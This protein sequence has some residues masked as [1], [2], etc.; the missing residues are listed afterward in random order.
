MAV[1]LKP[2]GSFDHF[3]RALAAHGH[4]R[5][6]VFEGSLFRSV[7]PEH[8]VVFGHLSLEG[9]RFGGRWNPPE[10]F[11]ALY[12]SCEEGTARAE[13]ER[14]AARY[15][16][17]PSLRRA[18]Q[19]ISFETR[20]RLHLLDLRNGELLEELGVVAADLVDED[21]R[22]ENDA[23]REARA[24][25]IGRAAYQVGLAGLLVNSAAHR[26]GT[27]VVLFTNHLILGNLFKLK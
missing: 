7:I 16:I 26:G 9:S 5:L 24:Q 17:S 10:S 1:R 13:G 18:R 15:G 27:N 22:S 11:T 21:W 2:H 4:E 3:S 20:T 6:R 8:Q 12:G 14:A 25:A 19:I 23:G